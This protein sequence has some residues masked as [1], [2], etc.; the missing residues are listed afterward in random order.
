MRADVAYMQPRTMKVAQELQD[1]IAGIEEQR[2]RDLAFLRGKLESNISAVN[3]SFQA[4]H[5]A[6]KAK[7][8]AAVQALAAR[9]GKQ[10]EDLDGKDVAR[11]DALA[12][13]MAAYTARVEANNTAQA[14]RLAEFSIRAS[15]GR[16]RTI[17][18]AV[19]R[20]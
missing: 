4:Q 5:A 11:T 19:P 9:L 20:R 18:S 1:A 12:K 6:E 13:R 16:T 7:A 3:A 2:R 8:L 15:R 17:R 14:A 10:R